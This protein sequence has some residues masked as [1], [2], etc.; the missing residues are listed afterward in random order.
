MNKK[1]IVKLIAVLALCFLIG[2]A[3]VACKGETGAQGPQG[4]QG[5]K[6]ETGATGAPGANGTNGVNGLTPEIGENGN[7]WIGDKDTGKPA[8]GPVGDSTVDTCTHDWQKVCDVTVEKSVNGVIHV[9][10]ILNVCNKCL[11]AK[12][13]AFDGNHNWVK[14][15]KEATCTEEGKQGGF[16]CACGASKDATTIPMKP[17]TMTEWAP[18][19]N[20]DANICEDGGMFAKHCT[21]CG[22]TETKVTEGEGHNVPAANWIVDKDATKAEEGQLSGLCETCKE[23]QT[24]T[25]PKLD[26][27]KYDLNKVDPTCT[28]AG[29][30]T[31]TYKVVGGLDANVVYSAPKITLPANGHQL[32]GKNYVEWDIN[33]EAAY[34]DAGVIVIPFWKPGTA[35]DGR[36][37]AIGVSEFANH[38]IACN[39]TAPAYFHCGDEACGE[40]VE[41]KVYKAHNGVS[42]ITTES[43]CCAEGTQT[44]LCDL[45]KTNVDGVPVAKKNHSYTYTPEEVSDGVFNLNGV[46]NGVGCDTCGATNVLENVRV[47]KVV[48]DATCNTEGKIVYTCYD[49]ANKEYVVEEIIPTT[50]HKLGDKLQTEYA[51]LT[52]DINGIL[53]FANSETVGCG[54][55]FQAYYVCGNCGENV[56]VEVKQAHIKSAEPTR[57][58]EAT[59]LTDKVEYYICTVDGCGVEFPKV[60]EGTKGHKYSY[61]LKADVNGTKYDDP[62]TDAVEHFALI[63]TCSV[64]DESTEGHQV[65]EYYVTAEEKSRVDATCKAAGEI[66]YTLNGNDVTV[67]IPVL[68]H[69]LD[70]M[71]VDSAEFAE[72]HMYNGYIKSSTPGVGGFA[73]V[74]YKCETAVEAHYTCE[75]CGK[76]VLAEIWR[77]HAYDE[78]LYTFKCYEPTEVVCIYEGCGEKYNKYADHDLEYGFIANSVVA[79]DAENAGSCTIFVKCNN[80]GCYVDG[81]ADEFIMENFELPELTFEGYVTENVS[82]NGCENDGKIK[83]TLNINNNGEVADEDDV[84]ILSIYFAVD[85]PATGH[86]EYTEETKTYTLTV[87]EGEDAEEYTVYVCTGCGQYVVVPELV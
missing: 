38:P 73:N 56:Y 71:L 85:V 82:A 84:V 83:Y 6:G 61:E 79:P 36:L 63:A 15:D 49:D 46:C 57:V 21:V 40:I 52:S 70:K 26:D 45:C 5:E 74:E 37:E 33:D 1:T 81:E 67:V 48:T 51:E 11:S 58:D 86:D 39:E 28:V 8:Q 68:A 4:P 7:W 30:E 80:E 25:L 17:H 27:V 65:I 87:G 64:C 20:D 18:V 31:Y 23:V 43:T 53:K 59:C 66:V 13:E 47:E 24:I 32:A 76:M 2:G 16:I 12:V 77:E 55:S 44:T 60:I 34:A 10:T 50:S 35:V 19:I 62:A 54:E 9:G 75:V 78:S 3:L 29:S 14:T 69:T 42:Q 41:V 22:H 72:K